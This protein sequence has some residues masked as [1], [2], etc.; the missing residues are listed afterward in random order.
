MSAITGKEIKE[1]E[2]LITKP[3][4]ISQPDLGALYDKLHYKSKQVYIKNNA[5]QKRKDKEKWIK[6]WVC[7]HEEDPCFI[8]YN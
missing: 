7:E 2:K 8:N 4:N 5:N 3:I 1:N 6:Q